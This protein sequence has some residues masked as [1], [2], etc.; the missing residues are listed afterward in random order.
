MDP[1]D[2]RSQPPRPQGRG[3]PR[4]HHRV[5]GVPGRRA[6]PTD[7]AAGPPD[8]PGSTAGWPASEPCS[9]AAPAAERPGQ[10]SRPGPACAGLAVDH[11]EPPTQVVREG[12]RVVGGGGV[13]PHPPGGR[14]RDA[15]SSASRTARVSRCP[16]N[17]G[18][19]LRHQPEHGDLDL[20]AGPGLQ[21][22]QARGLAADPRQEARTPGL[23]GA[24][25]TAPPHP[26]RLVQLVWPA[27]P[28]G[29]L[30]EQR[31]PRAVDGLQP[32]RRG[33]RPGRRLSGGHLQPGD[34]LLDDHR[35][36]R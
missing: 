27:D 33:G 16:P 34:G 24:R 14:P 23:P 30:A 2:G 21:L 19:Q 13:Q 4:L 5:Q 22:D 17:P 12:A 11:A 10:A 35:R 25:P 1:T 3:G 29:G 31:H 28:V 32:H 6:I 18:D 8:R 20:A 26:D 7:A 9:R 36:P 15:R